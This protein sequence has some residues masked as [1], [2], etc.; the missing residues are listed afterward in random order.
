[1]KKIQRVFTQS[2]HYLIIVRIIFPLKLFCSKEIAIETS[3]IC[4]LVP[5]YG[6]GSW[7]LAIFP[8]SPKVEGRLR[9]RTEPEFNILPCCLQSFNLPNWN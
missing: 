9:L 2:E 4:N 5:A 6:L 7:N 3:Y 1:M 8:D